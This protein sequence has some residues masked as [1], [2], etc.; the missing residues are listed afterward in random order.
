MG[1]FWRWLERRGGDGLVGSNHPGTGRLR[2]ASFRYRPAM[3]ERL[4]SL[5]IFNK[6]DDYLFKDRPG[7]SFAFQPVPRRRLARRPA[8]VTDEH[9]ADWAC[10][11]GKG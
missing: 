4:V 3:A 2:F 5:E 11:E 9:G 8:R 1:R 10:P 6:T 7:Q